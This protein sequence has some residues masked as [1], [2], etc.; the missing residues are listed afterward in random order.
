M[1]TT[2]P[3]GVLTKNVRCFHRAKISSLIFL[4]LAL[5]RKKKGLQEGL[6][7]FTKP[8]QP[9][10]CSESPA[11]V[12]L[13][14]G[15]SLEED[16][17]SGR[18]AEVSLVCSLQSS[19]IAWAEAVKFGLRTLVTVRHQFALLVP[20]ACPF[21]SLPHITHPNLDLCWSQTGLPPQ[22]A[23]SS[24]TGSRSR[25]PRSFWCAYTRRLPF[26]HTR[27]KRTTCYRQLLPVLEWFR[28]AHDLH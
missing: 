17:W 28:E 9:H 16:E 26:S 13:Q 14:L 21:L 27:L 15:N 1:M 7:M 8:Y 24:Q 2:T 4:A 19:V 10:S 5:V 25:C 22:A 12:T 23:T 6:F 11:M 20:S 3:V 18:R